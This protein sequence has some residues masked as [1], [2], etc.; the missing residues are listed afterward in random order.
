MAA[1]A[2]FLRDGQFFSCVSPKCISSMR[3][4]RVSHGFLTGLAGGCTPRRFAWGGRR[5][6]SP[7]FSSMGVPQG[8]RG[9]STELS[10]GGSH[11]GTQ[12]HRCTGA[13]AHRHTGANVHARSHLGP[14]TR[15]DLAFA[16]MSEMMRCPSDLVPTLD[17]LADGGDSAIF[18]RR[19]APPA[20]W[21]TVNAR[22]RQTV[23][24]R[25][26]GSPHRHPT[27]GVMVGAL[28]R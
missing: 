21:Q 6:L 17:K 4:A 16:S 27:P 20:P 18:L 1:P 8:C 23:D 22:V 25:V 7:A 14:W 11:T 2:L 9:G 10:R 3:L 13:Q 12:A 19:G 15:E 24:P 28:A 5:L 26:T